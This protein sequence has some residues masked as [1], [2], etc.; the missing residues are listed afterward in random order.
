[1]SKNCPFL[2][3]KR[4]YR[5]IFPG[6]SGFFPDPAWEFPSPGVGYAANTQCVDVEAGR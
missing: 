4:A 6:F 1:V 2:S 5:D 3:Y